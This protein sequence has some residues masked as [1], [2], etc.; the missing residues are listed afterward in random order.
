MIIVMPMAMM[1]FS[2]TARSTFIR[3]VTL[4]NRLRPFLTQM[5]EPIRKIA[6]SAM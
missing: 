3:F 5:I 4:K 2:D 6:I 1:P